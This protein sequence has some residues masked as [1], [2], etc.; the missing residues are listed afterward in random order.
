MQIVS[1]TKATKAKGAPGVRA[2]MVAEVCT[3]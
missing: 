3:G 1:T 2:V